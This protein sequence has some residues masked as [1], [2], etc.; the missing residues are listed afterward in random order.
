MSAVPGSVDAGVGANRDRGRAPSPAHLRA[1]RTGGAPAAVVTG[2]CAPAGA[3][4]RRRR[5]RWG[6]RRSSEAVANRW[7]ADGGRGDGCRRGGRV[8]PPLGCVG[9][10]SLWMQACLQRARGRALAVASAAAVRGATIG[11]RRRKH[12]RQQR[13]Q[14]RPGRRARRERQRGRRERRRQRLRV[15]LTDRCHP[16]PRMY[17]YICVIK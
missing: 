14:R 1:A 11:A 9:A 8:R 10:G 5:G 13:R 12:E 7:G 17:V 16:A 2:V 6:R 15:T 4:A 3:E